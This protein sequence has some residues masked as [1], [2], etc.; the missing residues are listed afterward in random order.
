MASIASLFSIETTFGALQMGTFVSIV[1]FRTYQ[2]DGLSLK[3]TVGSLW[4]FDTIHTAFCVHLCHHYLVSNFA[5][6][7]GLLY[8]VWSLS[9]TVGVGAAITLIANAYYVRRIYIIGNKNKI[10]TAVTILLSGLQ[11]GVALAA[12]IIS[13]RIKFLPDFPKYSTNPCGV[14]WIMIWGLS[15][16]TATDIVLAGSLMYLLQKGRTGYQKTDSIID[17]LMTYTMSTGLITSI[18]AT[19]CLISVVTMPTQF[20]YMAIHFVLKKLY[21]NSLLVWVNSRK[22]LLKDRPLYMAAATNSNQKD[23]LVSTP[24]SKFTASGP[25]M[26]IE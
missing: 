12:S 15:V 8:S 14:Q 19:V 25:I 3:L 7:L 10:L 13:S 18:T 24:E 2:S 21:S 9:G 17:K 5:N 6:P 23:N 11:F 1:Y 4:V 20:I 26:I 22:G 16:N